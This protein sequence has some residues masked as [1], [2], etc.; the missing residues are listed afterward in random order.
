[1]RLGK[2]RT[3]FKTD[4]FFTITIFLCEF[5]P[6]ACFI[7]KFVEIFIEALKSKALLN[8]FTC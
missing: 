1:M 8:A 2:R 6:A 4:Q 7:N 5:L 3:V